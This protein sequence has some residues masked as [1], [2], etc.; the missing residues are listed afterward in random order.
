MSHINE[1]ERTAKLQKNAISKGFIW[2][3]LQQV[4]EKVHEEHAEV[5]EA[6]EE[7]DRDHIM[8]EIGDLLFVATIFAS[9]QNINP[10]EA[11][12]RSNDKF[13]FRFNHVMKRLEENNADMKS[14]TWLDV[15]GY[16]NEAKLKSHTVKTA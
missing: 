14:L 11:L 10:V 15:K 4:S 3:N 9:Y 6:I 13:V 8:E 12:K 16:W 5:M 2:E 7:N 1:L